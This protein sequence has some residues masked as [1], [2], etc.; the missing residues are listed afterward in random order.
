MSITK[1]ICIIQPD[2][3]SRKSTAV[4]KKPIDIV[5]I[6]DMVKI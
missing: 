3:G 2:Q 5:F 1:E 4:D 6:H